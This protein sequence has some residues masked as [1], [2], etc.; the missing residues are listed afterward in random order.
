MKGAQWFLTP[1]C[2]PEELQ[3]N[4]IRFRTFDLGGHETA[5]R[6]WKV[7]R[8]FQGWK[9]QWFEGFVML[10]ES[11][12]GEDLFQVENLRYVWRC[13]LTSIFNLNF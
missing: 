11:Y 2:L 9:E 6:I 5:R 12:F 13:L 3:I 4:G 10:D 7:G 8:W 1:S